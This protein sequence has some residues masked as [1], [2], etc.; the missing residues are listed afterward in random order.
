MNTS[1]DEEPQGW[2]LSEYK[3]FKVSNNEDSG[4]ST[5][6]DSDDD[7]QIFAKSNFIRKVKYK[8][9]VEKEELLPE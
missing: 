7:E 3:S 2:T 1:D 6:E 8:K 4:T 9:I 5:D